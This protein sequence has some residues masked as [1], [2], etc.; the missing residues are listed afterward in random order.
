MS[1]N[2][3]SRK[4]PAVNAAD[5]YLDLDMDATLLNEVSDSDAEDPLTLALGA[6]SVRTP[7]NTQKSQAKPKE[8]IR[9][10]KAQMSQNRRLNEVM[11]DLAIKYKLSEKSDLK[12]ILAVIGRLASR[13]DSI[14]KRNKSVTKD[15]KADLLMGADSIQAC[16][17][18]L[19]EEMMSKF[20]DSFHISQTKK[21]DSGCQTEV[22]TSDFAC[23]TEVFPDDLNDSNVR[24]SDIIACVR[25]ELDKF[26]EELRRP[27]AA[28]S[29]ASAVK[30]GPP[31]PKIKV[32]KTR[33]AIVL[34]SKDPAKKTH[35]DVLSSW[36]KGVTFHDKDFAPARVQTIS[37]GKV[38]VEFDTRDQRDTAMDLAEK[39][40]SLKAEVAVRRR[41]MMILKGIAKDTD[42]GEGDIAP[43]QAM[44]NQNPD[45]K[46]VFKERA[47]IVFRFKRRNR[48][49]TLYNTVIEVSPAVR[50]RMLELGRLN[51]GHQRV[52]VQDYSPFVQCFGCLQ[53]GHTKDRCPT[54]DV[55]HCS[56]CA[57]PHNVQDCA[58]KSVVA[59]QRCFNC[60]VHNEKTKKSVDDVHSG[61]SAKDCPRIKSMMQRISERTCYE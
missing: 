50:V 41:P 49:E 21:S 52:R 7:P 15:D 16:I 18:L 51:I 13:T 38:R 47:D 43:L 58:L 42:I 34:E 45:L 32:P 17:K 56:H 26:R 61:T 31:R 60:K 33:P 54:P 48:K 55:Q 20:M 14:L 4:P 25:Q 19:T 53:F 46:D 10:R 12:D 6:T 30:S 29:Y 27:E 35:A 39:V 59:K 5:K 28:T 44:V 22:Q 23:Q 57:G 36:R 24:T 3:K 9:Q 1:R 37:N 40:S 8:D 11:D 2:P